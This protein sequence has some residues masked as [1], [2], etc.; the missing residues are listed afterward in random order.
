MRDY[1][2]KVNLLNESL[3][4]DDPY[5]WLIEA[6]EAEELEEG[7][8]S[9]VITGGVAALALG[10][11]AAGAGKANAAT[12]LP[13]EVAACDAQKLAWCDSEQNNKLAADQD[14]AMQ[15]AAQ[16]AT[17]HFRYDAS[18]QSTVKN[19][20]WRSHDA[21]VANKWQGDCDDLTLT[22]I[23]LAVKAGVSE[24]RL[25]RALVAVD[26]GDGKTAIGHIVGIY[27]DTSGN[28]WVVGDSNNPKTPMMS[29]KSFVNG[30]NGEIRFISTVTAG[31]GNWQPVSKLGKLEKVAQLRAAE[32]QNAKSMQVA[33]AGDT[34]H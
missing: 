12:V 27:E 32:E 8:W 4:E 20:V 29:M 10:A 3:A 17:R 28:F 1:I 16:A 25:Y 2:N 5:L 15:G 11:G 19:D 18:D 23:E 14:K 24:T 6:F 30:D 31:K 13:Q 26:K 21:E 33:Q 9:N 34:I 22:T 7:K